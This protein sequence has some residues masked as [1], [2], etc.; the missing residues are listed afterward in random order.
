MLLTLWEQ[1]GGK[2]FAL[3][4]PPSAQ[5]KVRGHLEDFG[6]EEGPIIDLS[7]VLWMT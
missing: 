1:F 7:H 2:H 5:S 4:V 6:A 3:I